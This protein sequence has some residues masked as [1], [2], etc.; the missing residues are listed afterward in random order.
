MEVQTPIVKKTISK[1]GVFN[2]RY[3]NKHRAKYNDYMREY[4]RKRSQDPV[5]REKNRVNQLKYYARKKEKRLAEKLA[6]KSDD[7]EILLQPK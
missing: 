2:Q 3:R 1:Q 7:E 4:Q 6:E 5:I